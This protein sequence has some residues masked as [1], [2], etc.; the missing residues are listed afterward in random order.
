MRN[1]P[2]INRLAPSA[3]R[4]VESDPVAAKPE[5]AAMARGGRLLGSVLGVGVGAGDGVAAPLLG[6]VDGAA[7]VSPFH[8]LLEL[9]EVLVDSPFAVT[10]AVSVSCVL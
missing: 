6:N 5:E 8:G 3:K 4:P 2:R 10:L 1:P 9:T 7:G